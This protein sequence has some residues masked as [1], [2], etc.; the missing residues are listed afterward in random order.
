MK[1][2]LIILMTMFFIPVV[3]C[4]K[5]I[6]CIKWMIHFSFETA[7]EVYDLISNYGKT[8]EL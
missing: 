7:E 8:E 6:Q 2:L 3:V 5:I 4:L 1:V